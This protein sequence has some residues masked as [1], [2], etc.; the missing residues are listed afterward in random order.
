LL[1]RSLVR[2]TGSAES[3]LTARDD[4]GGACDLYARDAVHGSS[5]PSE[6]QRWAA[7]LG[8]LSDLDPRAEGDPAV[9]GE[10]D[11][12]RAKANLQANQAN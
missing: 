12:Q 8:A 6:E 3:E 10:V 1:G 7:D 5:R 11:R 9:A 4:D 2:Q